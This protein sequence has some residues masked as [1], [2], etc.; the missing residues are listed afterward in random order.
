MT[1]DANGDIDGGTVGLD[2]VKPL[3]DGESSK[4]IIVACEACVKRIHQHIAYGI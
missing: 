1:H 4:P 3:P 2:V